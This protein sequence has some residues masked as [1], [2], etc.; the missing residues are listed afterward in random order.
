MAGPPP[1]S[2]RRPLI[3][4]ASWPVSRVLYGGG[5]PPRDGHSSWTPVARR[6]TLPT[7]MTG[8]ETGLRTHAR[9]PSLFGIAPGG[10]YHAG[11]VAR[12]AVGSY[13]TVSPLPQEAEAPRG[14]TL[15]C[16]TF[17]EVALAGRYPAPHF[18][19]AR[20]FLPGGLSTLAGAAVRPTDRADM[21]GGRGAVNPRRRSAPGFDHE[22]NRNSNRLAGCCSW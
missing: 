18:H 17:P 3:V 11:P 21:A 1:L 13:P 9:A 15:F 16:G 14:G 2:G 12:S 4:I 10:V 22:P 20:T 19:G 6:L 7:R 5:C 8:P